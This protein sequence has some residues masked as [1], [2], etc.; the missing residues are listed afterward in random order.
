MET[1]LISTRDGVVEYARREGN[2]IPIVLLSGIG[3]SLFEWRD[4]FETDLNIL[5]YN[6]AGY[7]QSEWANKER[8]VEEASGELISLLH[9]L[10]LQQKIILAGHS[11]GGLI[12]QDFVIR[13]PEL[14]FGVLL[15][16]ATPMDVE[17][18]EE[19]ENSDET[20]TNAYWIKKCATYA[21]MTKEELSAELQPELPELF[22][23]WEDDIQTALLDHDTSPDLYRAVGSEIRYMVSS[24]NQLD[25]SN[26]PNLPLTVIGRD[27]EHASKQQIKAGT[28]ANEVVTFEKVWEE[29]IFE[30]AQLA[31]DSRYIKATGSGHNIPYDCPELVIK[32]VSRLSQEL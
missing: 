25:K 17:R 14:V 32:E 30:Q 7:G 13:H 23:K 1:S 21:K 28:P 26:F 31:T 20:S 24:A 15:I 2:S 10:G 8:T 5:S 16:D 11:Y 9:S 18:I 4:F 3:G 12:A 19:I 27:G 29:L 6:R 22:R